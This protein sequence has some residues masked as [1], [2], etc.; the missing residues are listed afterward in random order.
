MCIRDRKE[1]ALLLMQAADAYK[2]GGGGDRSGGQQKGGVYSRR[3][4]VDFRP[5]RMA[6]PA[7]EL[8]SSERTYTEDHLG[9]GDLLLQAEQVRAVEIVRTVRCKGIGR[10][11]QHAAEHGDGGGVGGEMSVEMVHRP[12]DQPSQEESGLRQVRQMGNQATIGPPSGADCG[13]RGLKKELRPRGGS[14]GNA[15]QQPWSALAQ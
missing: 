13:S 6:A 14:P 15:G 10:A 5:M 4:H 7:Q 8:A 9:A 1:L 3:H 12:A 11:A 2:P